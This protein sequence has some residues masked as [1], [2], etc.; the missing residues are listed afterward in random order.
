MNKT[1]ATVLTVTLALTA[2][3]AGSATAAEDFKDGAKVTIKHK[4]WN[5]GSNNFTLKKVGKHSNGDGIYQVEGALKNWLEAHKDGSSVGTSVG[6][7]SKGSKPVS[8]WI[9]HK[10]SGGW[11]IMHASNGANTVSFTG[12]NLLELQRNQ[13]NKHQVFEIKVR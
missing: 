4:G 8:K 11:S 13:G 2:M 1:I 7:S 10:N 3:F 5:P 12:K 9:F 6:F